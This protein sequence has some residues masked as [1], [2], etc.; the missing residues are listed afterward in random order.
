MVGRAAPGN[1]FRNADIIMVP[2]NLLWGVFA[3][4]REV[5]ALRTAPFFF[6]L[7]GITFAVIGLYL[8]IGRFFADS[9]R[10]RGTF[11]WLAN[12]RIIIGLSSRSRS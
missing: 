3:I 7:W 11:Y 5:M 2:V 12:Q 10:R 6:A 1:S 8:M 4:A 9:L